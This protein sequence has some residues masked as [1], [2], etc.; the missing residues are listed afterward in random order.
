MRETVS[1]AESTS[2]K[3][4]LVLVA[5]DDEQVREVTSRA[6]RMQG[7][8]AVSASDG[9]E[10][11]S[12]LDKHPIDFLLTDVRMPGMSGLDLARE[13]RSRCPRIP[14]VMMTAFSDLEAA[15]AAAAM[16]VSG[17]LKKPFDDIMEVPATV[18]RI[19]GARDAD[20]DG[21]EQG[22]GGSASED[23]LEE[24]QEELRS[25][26]VQFLKQEKLASLGQLAAGIAH[27]LNNPIGFIVS[28]LN[29]LGQ[30]AGDILRLVMVYR[31]LARW[32]LA[33]DV[34]DGK[35]LAAKVR[36]LEEEVDVNFI[37]DDLIPLVTQSKE[38]ADRVRGIVADLKTFS[39]PG[40]AEADWFDINRCIEST[41]NIAWNAIK[42]QA[43]VE[44]DLGD[45]PKVLCTA[46]QINQVFLNLI[47]NSVQAMDE[48][49]VIS[50]RTWAEDGKVFIELGDTGKGMPAE[51][52]ERIFEPFFTT[53]PVGEGTG[54]GLSVAYGIISRHGG[55]IS[56]KSEL[57]EGTTFTITLPVDGPRKDAK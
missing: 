40:G 42:Y 39:H 5:D 14:I 22:D 17:Y 37:V 19:L 23:R 10:A 7:Y 33:C 57:G 27:E 48:K 35:A 46:S 6:L 30:Y 13:V 32:A 20:S 44:K 25:L 18:G 45:I 51:V 16:G 36:K 11:L 3:Q 12:C 50:A 15:T 43:D 4:T 24:A 56:V 9:A 21:D 34:E 52:R 28:N 47:M 1:E 41:L 31:K 54:L 53:K 38:G 8:D 49:G 2:S 55:D 29:T 26:Q